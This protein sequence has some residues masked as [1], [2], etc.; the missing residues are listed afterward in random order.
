[1][2]RDWNLI[3]THIHTHARAR[4]HAHTKFESSMKKHRNIVASKKKKQVC[5][6]EVLI[7]WKQETHSSWNARLFCIVYLLIHI[8]IIYSLFNRFI[9]LNV[10]HHLLP[11]LCPS[12]FRTLFYIYIIYIYTYTFSHSSNDAFNHF[13]TTDP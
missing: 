4:T 11:F 9:H 3:S 6:H 12:S 7:S 8:D 1:M 5:A 2:I 10:L 13:R